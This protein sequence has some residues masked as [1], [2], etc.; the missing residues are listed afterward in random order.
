VARLPPLLA[1]LLLQASFLL[2]SA[3]GWAASAEPPPDPQVLAAYAEAVGRRLRDGQLYPGEA[4]ATGTGGVVLVAFAIGADGAV[5]EDSLRV[6]RSSGVEILDAA[7]LATVRATSPFGPP[8]RPLSLEVRI[9]FLAP[10]RLPDQM[11]GTAV[12]SSGTG[13]LIDGTGAVLTARHVIQGCPRRIMVLKGRMLYPV[14]PPVLSENADLALLFPAMGDAKGARFGAAPRSGD[15]VF[16]L[17]DNELR[18][19][20][21]RRPLVS[22]GIVAGVPAEG[23]YAIFG[24][25]VPGYSGS[26][27][28]DADGRVVGLVIAKGI[29]RMKAG[30]FAEP[31]SDVRAVGGGVIRTF[32]RQS[33]LQPLE[34]D[35]GPPATEPAQ[36]VAAGI[37]VGIICR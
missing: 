36:T 4:R 35:A 7:A 12:V 17:G 19:T 20:S 23:T 33:G 1:A 6:S 11:A 32:L 25:A 18:R 22:N 30:G 3:T 28:L 15:P 16:L 31:I 34:G 27:V 13:F 26:P 24:H 5:R 2:L 29:N 8:P 10:L 37:S 14:P 21:T 9:R